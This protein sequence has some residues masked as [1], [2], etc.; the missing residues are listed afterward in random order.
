M[1]EVFTCLVFPA[2]RENGANFEAKKS[3]ATPTYLSVHR[4]RN[5]S[6]QLHLLLS[7]D[8]FSLQSI[9]MSL[10][11]TFIQQNTIKVC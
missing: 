9:Q 10:I 3:A 7:Y 6:N 8:I 11:V 2:L 1:A 4:H 5:K